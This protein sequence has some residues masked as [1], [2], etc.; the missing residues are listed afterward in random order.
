METDGTEYGDAYMS[1]NTNLHKFTS[2]IRDYLMHKEM[3]PNSLL[4]ALR[5]KIYTFPKYARLSL[6]SINRVSTGKNDHKYK[7]KCLESL[8]PYGAS[9]LPLDFFGVSL[10]SSYRANINGFIH[11]CQ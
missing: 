2:C 7:I 9:H 11:F 5:W 8:K 4:R 10:M 3:I 6:H 1:P